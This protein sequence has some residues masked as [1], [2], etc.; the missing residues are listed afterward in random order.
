MKKFNRMLNTQC[1]HIKIFINSNY[2]HTYTHEKRTENL[3]TEKILDLSLKSL[4]SEITHINN[5]SHIE[6]LIFSN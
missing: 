1:C 4:F 5:L 3:L 2:T 6:I